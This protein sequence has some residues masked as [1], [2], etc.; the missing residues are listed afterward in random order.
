MGADMGRWVHVQ[1]GWMKWV[2]QDDER[3]IGQPPVPPVKWEKEK[4]QKDQEEKDR[5]VYA[6]LNVAV[7]EQNAMNALAASRY[8]ATTGND[9]EDDGA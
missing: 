8:V 5:R 6:Y 3:P 4:S 1:D 9:N 7:A 2:G